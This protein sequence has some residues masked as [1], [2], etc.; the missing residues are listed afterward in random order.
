[1]NI[2]SAVGLHPGGGSITVAY[3][4]GLLDPAT[5]NVEK[6]ALTTGLG[7][8]ADTS[9]PGQVSIVV[10]EGAEEVLS[11]EGRLF[12]LVGTA[13]T[14]T[15]DTCGTV[16]VA[17]ADF[18][19][20]SGT[21]LPVTIGASGTLCVNDAGCPLGDVDDDSETSMKPTPRRFCG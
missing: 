9:D 20:A 7:I 5:L 3:P 14:P 6:T 16:A 11:G 2:S 18:Y 1:M 19:D 12:E 4:A 13:L 10:A 15:G 21:A 17:S 8:T